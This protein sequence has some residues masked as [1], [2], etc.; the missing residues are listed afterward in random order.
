MTTM[1]LTQLYRI[2]DT[3]FILEKKKAK[4]KKYIIESN[5]KVVIWMK[6]LDPFG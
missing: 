2:R 6:S 1:R 4:I 5:F 3:H